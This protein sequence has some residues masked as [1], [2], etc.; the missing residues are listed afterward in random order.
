[1]SDELNTMTESPSSFIT[2][3]PSLR[4]TQFV[5][6][7]SQLFGSLSEQALA[8]IEPLA[9]WIQ[10]VRG[11]A[12]FQQGDASDGLCVVV[13][14]RLQVIRTNSDGVETVIAEVKPGES[15]GEMGFF[16]REPRT[17]DVVAVRD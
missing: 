14:G 9:Q 17:A 3:H 5:A 8:T 4:H 7:A 6:A 15:I 12:L 11:E 13:S 1:M 16:T 10:L 2:H